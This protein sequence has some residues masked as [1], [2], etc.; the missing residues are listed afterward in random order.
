MLRLTTRMIPLFLIE[1]QLCYVFLGCEDEV[2]SRCDGWRFV[3]VS[4]LSRPKSPHRWSS[5]TRRACHHRQHAGHLADIS[6]IFFLGSPVFKRSTYLAETRYRFHWDGRISARAHMA[7]KPQHYIVEDF[8]IIFIQ[9]WLIFFL[10]SGRVRGGAFIA[11]LQ[12]CSYLSGTFIQFAPP[13]WILS[14]Y[15]NLPEPWSVSL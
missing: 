12:S 9:M 7:N 1:L 11:G 10:I 15:C 8:L 2:L 13:L 6:A 14:P 4:H 3:S 5:P